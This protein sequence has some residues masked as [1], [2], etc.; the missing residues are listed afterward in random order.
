MLKDLDD[1]TNWGGLPNFSLKETILLS[2]GTA[3]VGRRIDKRGSHRD[4]NK[5]VS[6]LNR[7]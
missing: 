6:P 2:E 3:K 1:G 7:D 5:S 4:I